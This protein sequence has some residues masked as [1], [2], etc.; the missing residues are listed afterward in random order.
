MKDTSKPL[1]L[2]FVPVVSETRYAALRL[3]DMPL[4]EQPV[5]RLQQI[6]ALSLSLHEL[7]ATIIGGDQ[8]L[9]IARD[10]L[11]RYDSLGG[12]VQASVQEMARISG[13]GPARAAAIKAALELGRRLML[14]DAGERP[15][16]RTPGDAAAILIPHLRHTEQEHFVVL[17]LDTRNRVLDREDL[18]RGTVN[19]SQVRVGEVFREAVR[20]NCAAIVVAH[21]HPSLD[22]SPSPDDIAL[23]RDIVAAGELL[24]IQVLDHIVLGGGCWISLRERGLGFEKA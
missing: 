7:L 12:I 22:P 20:R 15:Q 16:I 21:N 8:Q 14:E 5:R 1:Q 2:T 4:R 9:Q 11:A 13:L 24:G 23:T 18:Y 10:L 6:G 3:R 19:Q 17:L